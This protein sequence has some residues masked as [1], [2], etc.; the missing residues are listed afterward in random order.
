MVNYITNYYDTILALFLDHLRLTFGALAIAL[1]F[2]LPVGYLLTRWKSLS[3]LVLSI[4]GN[5]LCYS[6]HGIFCFAH[7]FFRI[8]HEAGYLCACRLQSADFGA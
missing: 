1:L 2:A 7:S 5:Y 6:Q 4:F 3:V 8:G